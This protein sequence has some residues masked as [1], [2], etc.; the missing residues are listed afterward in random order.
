MN[1]PQSLTELAM[2]KRREAYQ[3]RRV[4]PGAALAPMYER[5]AAELLALSKAPDVGPGR[6]VVQAQMR[7]L[8]ESASRS[9]KR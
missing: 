3:E 9:R 7:D 1:E 4:K 5:Q 2:G 6:E 8:H